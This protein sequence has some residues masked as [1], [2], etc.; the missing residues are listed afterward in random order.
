MRRTLLAL[1]AVVVGL[2]LIPGIASA[3]DQP[4]FRLNK[5]GGDSV[6]PGTIWI[7]IGERLVRVH[8]SRWRESGALGRG[9]WLSSWRDSDGNGGSRT[10]RSPAS[11]VTIRLGRPRNCDDGARIYTRFEVRV[12]KRHF[13]YHR[14]FTRRLS[15]LGY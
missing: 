3:G 1:I 7:L 6:R 4:V 11:S 9:M 5:N 12:T 15:C 10:R 8:W 13:R 2:A 14:G